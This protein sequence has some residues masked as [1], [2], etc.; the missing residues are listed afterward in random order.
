VR[1]ILILAALPLV[2]VLLSTSNAYA[3]QFSFNPS[4]GESYRQVDFT[5]PSIII[6]T[7]SVIGALLIVNERKKAKGIWFSNSERLK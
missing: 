3:A 6:V 2:V 5:V 7:A 1:A 4:T